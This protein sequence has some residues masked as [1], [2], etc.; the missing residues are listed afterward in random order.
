MPQQVIRD[1]SLGLTF[2]LGQLYGIVGPGLIFT[3]HLFEGLRR[4]MM[5]GDDGKAASRKLAATW[6]QARDAKLAGNDPHNLH[7]EHFPAEPNRVFCVYISRNEM[8]ESFPEIY[9]WLEHWTWIAADP[10]VP[11]A[12]IDFESRYDRQLWGPVSHRS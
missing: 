1:A 4:D 2:Y 7:L 8:L 3:Q 6:T 10:N 11:G 5:V 9:G 12:P